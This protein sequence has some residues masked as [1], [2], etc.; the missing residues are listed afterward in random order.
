M[1][2]ILFKKMHLKL[3]SA[4]CPPFCSGC[5]VLTHWGRVTHICIGNLTII[6]SD[7]GLSPHRRQAIIWSNAEI[8]L[9]GHVGTNFSEISTEILTF[10]FKKKRLKASSANSRPFC[11]SLNVLK[12]LKTSHNPTC[13]YLFQWIPPLWYRYPSVTQTFLN[14]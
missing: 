3:P 14:P 2:I 1:Q 9:I 6:G 13:E 7:N 11:L 12:R 8:L 5:N 4:K 10:S